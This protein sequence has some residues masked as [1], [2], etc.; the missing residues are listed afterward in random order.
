LGKEK[1]K[2]FEKNNLFA[3]KRKEQLFA[4][5]RKEIEFNKIL[6]NLAY[7]AN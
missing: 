5:K 7:A 6:H 1:K 4:F 3:F 2:H